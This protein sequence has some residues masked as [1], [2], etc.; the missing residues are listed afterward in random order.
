[1]LFKSPEPALRVSIGLIVT[2]ALFSLLVVGFLLY[3][4]TRARRNPV[5]TGREGL[6][7]EVGTARSD[8]APEGKVFVHGEIWDAVAEAP[9]REG[10]S[11]EVVGVRDMIL[12]VRPHG[13]QAV[14]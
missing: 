2:L 12:A 5:R 3:M 6:V 8:L 9:V 4:A 7:H 10:E 13:R 1:M 11:V 14:G